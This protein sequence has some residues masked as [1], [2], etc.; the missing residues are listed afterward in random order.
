MRVRYFPSLLALALVAALI[1]GTHIGGFVLSAM[2]DGDVVMAVNGEP[3]PAWSDLRWQMLQAVVDKRDARLDVERPG[4][5]QYTF[6]IS[7][8]SMGNI[9][10]DSDVLGLIGLNPALPPARLVEVDAS[11][12]AYLAGLR[13]DD[14]ITAIDGKRVIDGSDVYQVVRV[15][16][17]H[18]LHIDYLRA[19]QAG[20]VDATPV[21]NATAKVWQLKVR[22]DTT[23]EQTLVRSGPISALAK[24]TVQTWD[25]AALQLKFIGKMI[26]GELSLKNVTG[27]ITIAD[28]AGKT[29]RMGA[30]VF[31]SFIAM[32]SISL[33][34]MNLLPIPMLDGGHLLYYSLEVL[35]GRPLPDRINE[36]AQRAGVGLL[37]MLMAL[38]LFNDV[39]RHL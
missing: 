28:Y 14:V 17:G 38:A 33:G 39:A 7:D 5:G 11:G 8:A 26:I 32:V 31:L 18:S 21:Y 4:A 3:V 10:A 29:A 25:N 13:T 6:V 27:P 12:P 37:V 20:A 30:M 36:F 34:V 16:N 24:A 15:A 22:P 2:R 1:R 35:T 9:E 19:G 23:V